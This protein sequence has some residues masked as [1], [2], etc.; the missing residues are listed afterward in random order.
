MFV[1][2]VHIARGSEQDFPAVISLVEQKEGIEAIGNPDLSVRSYRTFGI[3]E[4]RN[5]SERAAMHA[6]ASARR[7][8]IIVADTITHEAQNALLKTL[9][10]APGNALFIILHPSPETLLSTVRSRAQIL[11]LPNQNEAEGD[12]DIAAFLAATPA[13]R[14]DMLKP[15]LEKDNDDKRNLGAI[16]AFL[17]GIERAL[18]PRVEEPTA[19]EGLHI[20]LSA[21][22]FLAGRGALVKPLLEQVALLV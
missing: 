18:L 12:V 8:F 15:L 19:Q 6:V 22:R 2:N 16:L 17:G 4:A 9:E 14:L 1:G 11:A 5:I 20:V 3:D 10:E 21:R 13:R 7:I